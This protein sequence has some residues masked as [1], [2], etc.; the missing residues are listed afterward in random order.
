[1][2]LITLTLAL[3]ALSSPAL[4][5][6]SAG[7]THGFTAGLLHPLVGLDHVLAMVAVGLWAGLVG[8]RAVWAWPAA[9]VALMVVSALIALGGVAA[10][11]A[12]FGIAA[13][14]VALGLLIALRLP[15]P[16]AAGAAICGAF[17]VFHGYAHGAEL[18]AGAGATAYV[19]GFVLATAALHAAGIGLGLRAARTSLPWLGR[20]AGGAVAAAGLV[21]L[22]A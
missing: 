10:P 18:P 6:T 16:L 22:V 9:F 20:A 11:G 19:V 17:A 4:A 2:R 13:S 1:M 15:L 21:L 5:H 7:A 8:G 14:V 3:A 12:E